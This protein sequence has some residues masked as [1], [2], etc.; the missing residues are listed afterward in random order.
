MRSLYWKVTLPFIIITTLGIA[1]L[2]IYIVTTARSAQMG[3]LQT[4]LID[5]SRLVADDSAAGF[6]AADA[7]G[8]DALAKTTGQQIAA[9]VTLIGIDGK[10]LGDSWE[11]P[12]TLENH[13]GRP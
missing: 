12:T 7:A 6:V 2:G 8:L 4:Y 10:V 3:Q 13:A 9:R 5:E 11:D 1:A